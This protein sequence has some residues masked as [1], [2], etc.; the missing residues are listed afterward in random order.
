MKSATSKFVTCLDVFV[1]VGACTSGVIS[2]LRATKKIKEF[3][4]KLCEV[5]K[6]LSL[7]IDEARD[8][9]RGIILMLIVFSWMTGMIILDI[10]SRSR[11]M[12]KSKSNR[13][14]ILN[15]VSIF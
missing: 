2:G 14:F 5:D 6:E 12:T 10:I 8:K 15:C 11:N 4:R 3:N 7:L 13:I 1:V 9:R